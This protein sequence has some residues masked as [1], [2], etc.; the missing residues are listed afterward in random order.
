MPRSAS[1]CG[2]GFAMGACEACPNLTAQVIE[3]PRVAQI[4]QGLVD[5]AGFT[6]RIKAVSHNIAAAPLREAYS[7]AVV[8]NLLQVMSPERA[9]QVVENVS[10]S[11]RPQWRS[12]ARRSRFL[13][14]D[15]QPTGPG[16]PAS[17]S[18]HRP[19]TNPWVKSG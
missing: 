18:K 2:A 3:L 11:L 13:A 14:D 19:T 7:A 5:A 12:A 8:R 6:S 1:A 9:Q 10:R 4:A 15:H 16:Q 17:S